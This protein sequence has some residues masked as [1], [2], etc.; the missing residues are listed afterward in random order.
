MLTIHG[1]ITGAILLLLLFFAILFRKNILNAI[2]TKGI[3]ANIIYF[4]VVL[5]ISVPSSMYLHHL[6]ISQKIQVIPHQ[7]NENEIQ[8]SLISYL[9]NNGHHGS[10]DVRVSMPREV[11]SNKKFEILLVFPSNSKEHQKIG[12]YFTGIETEKSKIILKEYRK[13]ISDNGYFPTA[14]GTIEKTYQFE[15]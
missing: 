11:I 7:L 14:A 1:I 12:V 4:I 10:L 9:R 13:D 2:G 8:E 3:I 5:G 15:L 6:L